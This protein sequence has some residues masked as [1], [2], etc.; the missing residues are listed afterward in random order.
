MILILGPC[1]IESGDIVFKIAKSLI[2]SIFENPPVKTIPAP[3]WSFSPLFSINCASIIIVSS[4]L[5]YITL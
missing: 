5:A 4:T 2:P 3:S 1:V